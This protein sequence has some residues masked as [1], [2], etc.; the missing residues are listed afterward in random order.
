MTNLETL[1]Q[2]GVIDS[3]HLSQDHKDVINTKMTDE[4]VAAL[5]SIKTKLAA[6][7]P[8]WA[9]RSEPHTAHAAGTATTATAKGADDDGGTTSWVAAL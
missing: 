4:E 2:A 5:I 7:G 6:N 8:A 1:E 3:K 9:P